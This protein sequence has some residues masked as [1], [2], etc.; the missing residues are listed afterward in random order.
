MGREHLGI[1]YLS[2]VLKARGHR[3]GLAYDPGYFSIQ[4]NT[5]QNR[6]LEKLFSREEY[7]LRKIEDEK[8]DIVAFSV[9][10]ESFSSH[11]N[12]ARKIKERI[13]TITV[14][15]G[16]HATLVP[17]RVIAHEVVDIVV[18]GEGENVM[19]KVV[20]AMGKGYPLDDIHNI[21]FKKNGK[22]IKSKFIPDLVDLDQL[23][24][25]DKELF[26]PY[27]KY[28]DDY[29]ALASRGCPYS[30]TFCSESH[31]NK[32]THNLNFR[33]RSVESMIGEL[34]Y[35]K[36]KYNIREIIF[37][38]NIFHLNKEWLR[39]FL[40]EYSHHIAVPFKC[41]GHVNSFDRETA[42]LLKENYCYNINFGLQSTDP[43]VR[44]KILNR[45]THDEKISKAFSHCEEMH[46]KF[47]VDIIFNLPSDRLETVAR[48]ALLFKQYKSLNRIKC[49][50]LTYYPRLEIIRK[51]QA[52]GILTPED[53][54]NIESG[55]DQWPFYMIPPNGKMQKA[56]GKGLIAL[57]KILPLLP[58]FV[59]RYLTKNKRYRWLG[60][61]PA[62][63]I[64]L[65]QAVLAIRNG[66]YRFY[67]YFKNYL[68]RIR[69]LLEKM[70]L[71]AALPKRKEFPERAPMLAIG[72]KPYETFRT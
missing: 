29:L 13:K 24:Y 41:L 51:A 66:D 47:D 40:K 10:T 18:I 53:M 6:M 21:Y 11:I 68:R 2:S 27:I 63:G 67:I 46:L 9:Y 57:Y 25:P 34:S 20:E 50:N 44:Q 72:G 65:L 58:A 42:Q 39:K 52:E 14:F 23:P 19:V 69:F 1:E 56:M 12:L 8:P 15:G 36:A 22:I 31:F 26:A 7:I 16:S 71:K 61:V 70:L 43:I 55:K 48:N 60:H 5:I 62:G 17:D 45:Y 3:V 37:F 30:C 59:V 28:S 54:E 33:Q 64:I 32:I 38:D 35:M 4:D 49:F